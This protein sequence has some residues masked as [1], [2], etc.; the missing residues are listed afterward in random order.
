MSGV[1]EEIVASKR[2]ELAGGDGGVAARGPEGRR[3]HKPRPVLEVLRRP[4]PS[5]AP[6]RLIAE[7][8]R[9]SP[10]AGALSCA[11]SPA[12]RALA[13][14]RAGATMVSVLCD[15]PFFDGAWSHVGD[16][17]DALADAGLGTL[18]LAK[19][20]VVDARAQPFLAFGWGADALLAIVRI[21][22]D[23]LLEKIVQ[24]CRFLGV[25]PLVEIADEAEL[26]RALEAGARVVGVNARDLDTL[27]MDA[28][29]AARVLDAVP[30]D[31]VAV[32]LSGLKTPDDVRAVAATRA[33]AALVGEALM[34]QDDPT[35]LLTEMVGAASGT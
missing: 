21:V 22:D 30:P 1:L 8:K 28:A 11:L 4:D 26:D 35:E 34:R 9:R 31:I 16:V 12:E 13:Y 29:R 2:R 25:E 6:L 23:E 32:H 15:G 5:S 3:S 20:F 14:A 27:R 17:R 24:G 33:D 19:E 10:S 18:V 7:I